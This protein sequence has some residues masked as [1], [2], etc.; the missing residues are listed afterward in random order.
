MDQSASS[1]LLRE[2]YQLQTILQQR[3]H[4][5]TW[6]AIDTLEPSG[7][8]RV[9][10]KILQM[11]QLQDWQAYELFEREALALQA[12]NHR[13]I[14]RL[15]DFFQEG[16]QA[17]VVQQHIDGDTLRAR[18]DKRWKLTE[19]QA[20]AL[21]KQALEILTAV[22]S[23]DPPLV[24]RDLKPENIMLDSKDQLYIID[25]GAVR[26]STTSQHTVA[27]SFAY[28][29]PEQL[30]GD[31][32]P[33][34]DLYGLGMTLIEILS[35]STLD[36]LPREGLYVKFHEAL[37][38][39]EGFKRW[40]DHMIAPYAVQRFTSAKAALEAL[41]K[42][43]FLTVLEHRTTLRPSHGKQELSPVLWMQE[44]P[45]ALTIELHSENFNAGQSLR[46]LGWTL[47]FFPVAI[48]SQ[49]YLWGWISDGL[50]TIPALK[51]AVG[52]HDILSLPISMACVFGIYLWIHK[53]Y[54]GVVYASKQ[55][56]LI[57]NEA[58][59]LTFS[60]SR[61]MRKPKQKVRI[62]PLKNL[63]GLRFRS[64][65]IGIDLHRPQ[66][67][68]RTH[69]ITPQAGFSASV[70]ETLVEAVQKRGVSASV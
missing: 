53:R 18:I 68:F 19:V 54:L 25:F 45:A 65:Q 17:I 26:Q 46:A 13:G 10:V 70:R 49:Y 69:M 44:T 3:E 8:Q 30:G 11:D 9:I 67:G 48:V 51:N 42:P 28:M 60:K 35:G 47:F 31:A 7:Q 16:Q 27:G 20:R 39:S 40:L 33:A 43:E 15:I 57:D 52:L 23:A 59:T 1:P 55:T 5:T 2:R 38:V 24:H 58:L 4:T 41:E 6:D 21:A 66:R 62:Y 12:L 37:H 64:H 22:H 61:G 63:R 29:A 32:I 50:A 14:P 36:Q 34:S 56:L